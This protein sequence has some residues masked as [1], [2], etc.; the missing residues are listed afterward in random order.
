MT[1]DETDGTSH[2]QQLRQ[3]DLSP[4]EHDVV[5]HVMFGWLASYLA[6]SPE[7]RAEWHKALAGGLEVVEEKR[8]AG[9]ADERRGP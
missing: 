2:L 8:A 3:L 9:G 5:V 7:G 6:R 4:D 1:E